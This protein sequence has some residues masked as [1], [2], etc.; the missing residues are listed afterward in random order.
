M[1]LEAGTRAEAMKEHCLPEIFGKMVPPL[2]QH[3]PPVLDTQAG[4]IDSNFGALAWRAEQPLLLAP[5]T[6]ELCAKV[7]D[8]SS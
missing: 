3:S 2:Q 7:S 5:V 6:I 1:N 4:Y 8:R